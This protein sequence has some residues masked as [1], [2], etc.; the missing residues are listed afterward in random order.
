MKTDKELLFERMHTIGEMPMKEASRLKPIEIDDDDYD[1]AIDILN[2]GVDPAWNVEKQGKMFIGV[3]GKHSVYYTFWKFI[4]FNPE[5]PSIQPKIVYLGNL[6]TN[7]LE[8]AKKARNIAGKQPV[9]L[10]DVDTIKGMAGMPSDIIGFGKYRGQGIGEVYAKDPQYVI[11]IAKNF[12]ARNKK[13]QE[14]VDI[15][16]SLSDDYFQSMTDANVAS[17]TKDYYGNA[18]DVFEGDLVINNVKH[19][20][21]DYGVSFGIKAENDNHRFLFYLP[22]N[23]FINTFGININYNPRDYNLTPETQQNIRA[24]KDKQIKI[25]GKVKAHKDIVGKKH[26][27]L[28]YVKVI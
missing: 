20:E 10:D 27:Q 15:A 16:K 18:G 28:N 3:T 1:K 8:A 17:E 11:W 19:Y 7:I 13:Q 24:L 22:A 25:K 14:F 6:S 5:F 9:D 4:P 23:K 26:T 21:G 12:T 2:Q